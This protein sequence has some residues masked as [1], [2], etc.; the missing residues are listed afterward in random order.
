MES[1]S[2]PSTPR[3]HPRWPLHWA[4]TVALAL[5]AGGLLA[6][7]FFVDAPVVA[8][9]KSTRSGSHNHTVFE[10][11]ELHRFLRFLESYGHGFGAALAFLIVGLV[12][13]H[14]RTALR[15]AAA[16]L[17]AAAPY[18]ILAR[19]FIH[20]CRPDS[21]R[22]WASGA[23]WS[24]FAAGGASFPS[25]HTATAVAFSIVLAA[26]YPRGRWVFLPLAVLCGVARVL[27]LDHFVSDVIAG[28][29]LGLVAGCLAVFSP[30]LTR[31]L[32]RIVRRFERPAG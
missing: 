28:A 18:L 1:A 31:L 26:A 29:I 3:D 14:W 16:V 23:V 22:D 15:L 10:D 7:S 8:G 5:V 21:W 20:R 32:N 27:T 2:E 6:A 17:M 13:H 25:G 30:S 4:A 11:N 9:I 19:L 12:C 24:T